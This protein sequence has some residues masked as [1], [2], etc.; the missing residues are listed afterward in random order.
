MS[1]GEVGLMEFNVGCMLFGWVG[2]GG[3]VL[4][5]SC[6]IERFLG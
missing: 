2:G 5:E 1:F 3:A 6:I 4:F